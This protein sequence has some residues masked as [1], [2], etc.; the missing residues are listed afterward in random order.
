MST[1]VIQRNL[2]DDNYVWDVNTLAWVKMTQ[3]GGGGS[4]V[5]ET[6]A[7]LPT[8]TTTLSAVTRGS[9]GTTDGTSVDVAGYNA[10]QVFVD[11]SPDPL[12]GFILLEVSP[13]NTNWFLVNGEAIDINGKFFYTSTITGGQ[14]N[15]TTHQLMV[16]VQVA[17]YRFFRASLL[18]TGAGGSGTWTVKVQPTVQGFASSHIPSVGQATTAASIPVTLASDQPNINTAVATVATGQGKTLVYG[19]ITQ[20]GVGTTLLVAADATRHIKVINYVIVMS[21]AGN[22]KFIDSAGDLTGN[23]PLAANSGVAASSDSSTP[24]FQTGVNKSLS[25]V[26]TGGAVFGHFAY[27]LE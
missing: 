22:C 11:G 26:T 14:L 13:D 1:V 20:G 6:A 15:G 7:T 10:V 16:E 9:A 17:G 2:E 8:A 18:Y 27:F 21:A 5:S 12:L 25:I 19:S 4:V 24:W 23:M 3:P